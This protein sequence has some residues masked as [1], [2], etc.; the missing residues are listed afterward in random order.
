MGSE[1]F[2]PILLIFGYISQDFP[3]L[4]CGA[5]C[6]DS[7]S[8]VQCQCCVWAGT[9]LYCS[10]ESQ[11]LTLLSQSWSPREAHKERAVSSELSRCALLSWHFRVL[12]IL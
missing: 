8:C 12:S 5:R 10:Q 9:G 11:M 1:A 6:E 2:C 3:F 4:K 7:S